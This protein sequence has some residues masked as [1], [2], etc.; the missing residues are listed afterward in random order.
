MHHRGI[1]SYCTLIRLH[2]GNF[3]SRSRSRSRTADEE[4]EGGEGAL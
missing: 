2:M 4:A 3:F 1:N